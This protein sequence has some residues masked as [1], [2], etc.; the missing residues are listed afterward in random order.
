MRSVNFLIF[1]TFISITWEIVVVPNNLHAAE[2]MGVEISQSEYIGGGLT[3]TIIG[4]G[5]GHLVQGQTERGL[6]FMSAQL[7]AVAVGAIGW[8]KL[9]EESAEAE[10]LFVGAALFGALRVYESYDL[11]E[12]PIRRGN[13]FYIPVREIRISPDVTRV[14]DG[15]WGFGLVANVSF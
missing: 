9:T 3:G 4:F 7:A 10:L 12:R 1:V 13:N 14:K 5:T 8:A 2:L 15:N 11:W 6:T